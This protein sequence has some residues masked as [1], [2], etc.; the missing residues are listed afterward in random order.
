MD[1][2]FELSVEQQVFVPTVLLR[3]L[4]P[5]E[6]LG[7]VVEQVRQLH[8]P[9]LDVELVLEDLTDYL[10]LLA[11]LYELLVRAF[12]LEVLVTAEHLC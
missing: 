5:L 4:Q 7:L 11:L 8:H 9:F 10:K 3:D 2:L 12:L 6:D 1:P